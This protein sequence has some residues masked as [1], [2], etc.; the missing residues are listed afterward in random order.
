MYDK[1]KTAD[2]QAL[3]EKYEE[4]LKT[5]IKK[6]QRCRDQIKV[7]AASSE[8]KNKAP[9]LDMRKV[10]ER[11]METFKVVERETKMKAFSKEGLA[12]DQPMTAEERKRLKSREWVQEVINALNDGIDE[13]EAEVEALEASKAK[14]DHDTA[15]MLEGVMRNH[16]F[17]I[18]KLE[19]VRVGCR[20]AAAV[21]A[22]AGGGRVRAPGA[23]R[24][25]ATSP[26]PAPPPP[27]HPA[28]HAHAGQRDAGSRRRG[29]AEG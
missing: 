13:M 4:E 20:A 19:G 2:T 1:V 28:A 21:A 23:P 6:L 27:R 14:K 9:L 17:H 24:A 11:R 18:D 26:P 16:R 3:K 15:A 8:V 22:G 10:I 5:S 7:W 29:C 25:P 12:R